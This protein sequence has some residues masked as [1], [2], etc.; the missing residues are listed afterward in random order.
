MAVS[1]LSEVVFEVWVVVLGK[2]IEGSYL[3]DDFVDGLLTESLYTDR[4]HDPATTAGLAELVIE[5]TDFGCRGF[6]VHGAFRPVG[7]ADHSRNR[8][9]AAWCGWCWASG[10]AGGR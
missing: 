7:V 2:L 5:G 4:E 3:G 6:G 1:D 10:L 8:S 9:R